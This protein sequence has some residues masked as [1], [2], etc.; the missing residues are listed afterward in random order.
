MTLSRAYARAQGISNGDLVT[1]SSNGTSLDLR[2][3]L[4]NEVRDGVA[5]VADEHSQGL[6]GSVSLTH[7]PRNEA[8]A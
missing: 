2:A 7:S 6:S 3:R 4:S 5:L 8:N 1:I